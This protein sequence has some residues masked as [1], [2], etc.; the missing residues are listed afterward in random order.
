MK[1]YIKLMRVYQWVKNLLIFVPCFFAEEIFNLNMMLDAF[2][3]F[4]IFSITASAVYI[5]N[6]LFDIEKDRLHPTKKLRPLASGLVS[7]K[8]A[9]C[10]VVLLSSVV[11]IIIF[12]MQNWSAGIV[13]VVYVLLNLLYSKFL[14]HVVIVDVFLLASFYVI[15]IAFGG[16]ITG[17]EIS[18]YL[19][20]TVMML[21]I[22]LGFGKRRNEFLLDENEKRLVLSKY[23]LRFLNSSMQGF[24]VLSVVFY[25]L[26]CNHMKTFYSRNFMSTI[27]LVVLVL[28]KYN[29]NMEVSKNDDPVDIVLGDKVLLG[30]ILIY[31][32]YILLLLYF[33]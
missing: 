32:I 4:V 5:I 1:K 26:W 27:P 2:E 14:K 20:L 22:Y 24:L 31:V 17:V 30:T 3:G 6:D 7:C 29:L 10:L 33:I 21:A 23:T 19:W 13:L 9:Y 16:I 8:K 15:R 25:S 11:I 18:D 28:L 12:F